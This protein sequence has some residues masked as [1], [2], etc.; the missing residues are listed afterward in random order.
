MIKRYSKGFSLLAALLILAGVVIYN[1]HMMAA[2]TN[3]PIPVKQVHTD[4]PEVS[5]IS[6]TAGSHAATV[7]A[8]GAAEPHYKLEL[9]SQ[10]AGRVEMLSATFDSGRQVK[11]GDLL[12]QLES[13]NYRAALAAAENDLA[14]AEVDFLEAQ[15]EAEQARVEWENSGLTGE[16]DSPLVLRQPQLN[17][18]RAAVENARAAVASARQELEQTRIRAP[19]DALI[20]SRSVSPGSFLQAGGAVASLYST[21]WLQISLPMSKRDW[22]KLPDVQTLDEGEW[23]VLF[24]DVETGQQWQGHV[25]RT[26]L[27]LDATTRQQSLIAAVEKPLQQTPVLAPGTFVRA[28]VKGRA[29]DDLWQ[30]PASSLS[31]RGEIWYVEA[32]TLKKFAADPVSSDAN[33]INVLPPKNLQGLSVQVLVH[34][35]SSYIEGMAVVAREYTMVVEV[36]SE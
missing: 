1:S 20:V 29:M 36:A 31:Q 5:V 12:L 15:R 23:P 21:D 18:A 32:D 11:K 28:E 4:Y 26:E 13:S 35:L 9:T 7:E 25:L 8:F 24:T 2:Q 33:V 16:P 34:P 6:V 27:H 19:F 22:Q 30:L 17:A 14:T 3:R 10:L